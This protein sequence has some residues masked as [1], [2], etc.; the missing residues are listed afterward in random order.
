M[1]G[2]IVAGEC[3]RIFPYVFSIR[4][5]LRRW[6]PSQ[7]MGFLKKSSLAHS[8]LV[9]LF[10]YIPCGG[11]TFE[12][13]WERGEGDRGMFLDAAQHFWVLITTHVMFLS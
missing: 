8:I 6:D 4:C 12:A 1:D 5:R 9:S 2:G 7:E 11:P 10:V 3:I 13:T